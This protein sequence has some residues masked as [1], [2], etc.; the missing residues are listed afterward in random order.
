MNKIVVTAKYDYSK[1][2]GFRFSNKII[3]NAVGTLLLYNLYS[4]FN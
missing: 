4:S 1:S 2:L 3:W